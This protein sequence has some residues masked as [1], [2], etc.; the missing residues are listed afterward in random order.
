MRKQVVM[1]RDVPVGVEFEWSGTT[2]KKVSTR[3][4]KVGN[5]TFYFGINDQCKIRR[6]GTEHF[7]LALTISVK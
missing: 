1:F 5:R 6:S 3:T 4:A 7:I 2:W